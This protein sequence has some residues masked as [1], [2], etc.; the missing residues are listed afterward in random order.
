LETITVEVELDGDSV[1][2]SVRTH[3]SWLIGGIN[4]LAIRTIL[5]IG[6][7]ERHV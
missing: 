5:K 2:M 4:D 1:N 6:P 3:I 7:Q